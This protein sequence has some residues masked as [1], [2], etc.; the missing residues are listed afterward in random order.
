MKND[1]KNIEV[2]IVTIANKIDDCLLNT[3]SNVSNQSYK[4]INHIIIYRQATSEEIQKIQGFSH[5]KKLLIYS[6]NG[7]G[8]ASAFNNGINQGHGELIL[9][10][11]S[12]DSLV[13]ADVIDQIIESY[14]R[15]RWLWASGETISVTKK[16]YLKKH[17]KQHKTWESKLFWYRNPIC[18]QSTIYSRKLVEQVGLYNEHLLMGMD[19]E[20]NIR[21]NLRSSPTLLYFPISYYDTTGISSI[22]VFEQFINHKQVRDRY[23]QLPFLKRLKVDAYCLLKAMYRLAMVPVK[24]WL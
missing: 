16:K 11:N 3:L 17:R 7:S 19:Y 5:S 1:D 18:H 12:G 22:K 8:I 24:L 21:S 14:S 20:Y 23:F 2:D 6:Q 13:A 4:E 10:L 9:F 15:E